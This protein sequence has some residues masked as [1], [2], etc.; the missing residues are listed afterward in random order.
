MLEGLSARLCWSSLMELD[1]KRRKEWVNPPVMVLMLTRN[2]RGTLVV[3]DGGEHPVDAAEHSL[4]LLTPATRRYV[5]SDPEDPLAVFAIGVAVEFADGSDFFDCC[6]ASALEF[7]P[8]VRERTAEDIRRLFGRLRSSGRAAAIEAQCLTLQV[9][10]S[11]LEIC[12][13][14]PDSELPGA[15][16]RCRRAVEYLRARYMEETDM[17]TLAGMCG[18]S[19][20]LFFRA[21]R[22]ETGVTPGEFRLR[23]RIREAQKLLLQKRHSVAEITALLGWESPFFFSRIFKRET[24]LS[25]R[26]FR[27]R[28]LKV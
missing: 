2:G 24:G 3:R 25:P 28:G 12:G 16:D 6:R 23:L 20:T 11:A 1:P 21:F 5:V 8:P 18:M 15:T 17:E 4:F 7:A 9:C 14:R 26:A 22:S 13:P 19:R 27:E 10:A